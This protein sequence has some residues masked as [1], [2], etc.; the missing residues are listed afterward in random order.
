MKPTTLLTLFALSIGS[1]RADVIATDNF[2][3][4]N[5]VGGPYAGETFTGT[6]TYDATVPSLPLLSFTTDFPS[7]A[8]ASLADVTAAFVDPHLFGDDTPV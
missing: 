5:V 6:F 3:I 7:W 2:T 4:F 8:G 1:A